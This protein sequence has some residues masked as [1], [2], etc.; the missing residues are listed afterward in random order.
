MPNVGH[1]IVE[2]T[3]PADSLAALLDHVRSTAQGRF[4][5]TLSPLTHPDP[6]PDRHL[7]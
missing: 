7:S 5:F 3:V 4:A 1:T 2:A 6:A